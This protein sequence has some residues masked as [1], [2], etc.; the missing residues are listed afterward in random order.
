MELTLVSYNL[1]KGKTFWGKKFSFEALK[2]L[3]NDYE[4]DLA[5]LQ[6][7]FGR[8][9]ANEIG[10]LEQLADSKWHDFAF[11]KNSVVGN[12]DHGNAVI[13]K[14]PIPY[15]EQLDLTLNPLEKRSIILT[16]IEIKGIKL[17]CLTTHLN[18]LERPRI[19]QVHKIMDFIEEKCPKDAPTILCGDFNDWSH[20]VK[21]TIVQHH[22]FESVCKN[23]RLRTFPS[24]F[25]ILELD[26]IFIK[27]LELSQSWVGKKRDFQFYSD[28]LPIFCKLNL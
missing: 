18:L 26:K 25:P 21:E 3:L 7:V 4:F 15:E 16:Q 1:H 14:Y 17:Y 13:S 22:G 11:A 2:K 8:S 27:N 19:K 24:M 20:K 28:H 12:F 23:N 6:E 10:H 9:Q 5:C